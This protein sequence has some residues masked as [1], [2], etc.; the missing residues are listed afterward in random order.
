MSIDPV[1]HP[2]RMSLCLGSWAFQS[3]F[4]WNSPT[5]FYYRVTP[6]GCTWFQSLFSWNSPSDIMPARS[7]CFMAAS[8]FNPCFRGTRPRTHEA[9]ESQV[10]SIKFQSLFSWNSPSDLTRIY[11]YS[12]FEHCF[13][14]CFR[15]T[16]PRTYLIPAN[17]HRTAKFQSLFSWNSPSDLSGTA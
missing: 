12:T 11:H 10:V 2:S 1:S 17:R 3:L 7:S 6:Q 9:M 14:P 8:R 4:S 13:N 16:R 15:G 5:D